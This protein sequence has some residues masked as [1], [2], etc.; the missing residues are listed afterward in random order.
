M[1]KSSRIDES[2][3]AAEEY[4]EKNATAENYMEI[5]DAFLAGVKFQKERYKDPEIEYYGG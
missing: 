1:K 3:I 5:F 4:A 2:V